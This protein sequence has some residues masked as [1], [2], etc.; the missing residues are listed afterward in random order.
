MS[1][2]PRMEDVALAM[3]ESLDPCELQLTGC[4]LRC[5]CCSNTCWIYPRHRTDR[6]WPVGDISRRV[7]MS[8]PWWVFSSEQNAIR[9]ETSLTWHWTHDS[10]RYADE[11]CVS[12]RE[13]ADRLFARHPHECLRN[14]P[15]PKRIFSCSKRRNELQGMLTHPSDESSCFHDDTHFRWIIL[16]AQTRVSLKAA[17]SMTIER[18]SFK[19]YF[20]NAQIVVLLELFG[21]V[22][23]RIVMEPIEILRSLVQSSHKAGTIVRQVKLDRIR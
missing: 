22:L 3:V 4:T 20:T 12:V 18:M 1:S 23:S 16:V 9:L 5:C 19:A 10:V 11:D 8:L 13:R 2:H 7:S 17:S 15:N 14:W 6:E 21:E